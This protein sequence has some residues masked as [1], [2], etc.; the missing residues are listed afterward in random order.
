MKM[1]H[2]HASVF[3]PTT[4]LSKLKKVSRMDLTRES[5]VEEAC[6]AY[7]N[8]PAIQ[9]YL[10]AGRHRA[11]EPYLALIKHFGQ[12]SIAEF[13]DQ[14][15]ASDW[16]D[17]MFEELADGTINGIR[18]K[19][20]KVCGWLMEKRLVDENGWSVIKRAPAGKS[21]KSRTTYA[22]TQEDQERFIGYMDS[23]KVRKLG[24]RGP[25]GDVVRLGLLTGMRYIELL[26]MSLDNVDL[27]RGTALVEK[28][29][30]KTRKERTVF[31]TEQAVEILKR[32][33]ATA[34]KHGRFFPFSYGAVLERITDYNEK[35]VEQYGENARK[36]YFHLTRHTAIT[37]AAEVADNIEELKAFSGHGSIGALERYIHNKR[38]SGARMAEKM[39]SRR[40]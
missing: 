21:K 8:S 9:S 31:L 35:L 22:L 34:E 27:E 15:F 40:V 13:A 5:T 38:E 33:K 10:K 7:I 26:M 3:A 25:Y 20:N 30:A 18:S 23:I 1:Y 24:Q 19:C 28:H 11:A 6:L 17:A 36:V 14:T 32:N 2:T 37:E 12:M 4:D 29:Y 39:N 16:K